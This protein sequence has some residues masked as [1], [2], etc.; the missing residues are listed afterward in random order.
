MDSLLVI[1]DI[2]LAFA[3]LF[4]IG[5]LRKKIIKKYSFKSLL[6]KKV[7][8]ASPI[9]IISIG[10]VLFLPKGFFV[11]Y[12]FSMGGIIYSLLLLSISLLLSLFIR[13][14]KKYNKVV[15]WIDN[16]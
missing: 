13:N 11:L 16:F 12:A 8:L 14:G 1:L 3:Y 10:I 2:F 4:L 9:L 7:I 6:F 15:K 5:L